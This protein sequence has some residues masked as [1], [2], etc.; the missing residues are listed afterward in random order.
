M[1]KTVASGWKEKQILQIFYFADDITLLANT[2]ADLQSMTTKL[3][4]K[5]ESHDY[6]RSHNV[7]TNNY[8]SPDNW[9]G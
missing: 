9:R 6:W 7:P 4:R 8:W 5:D 2:K 3:Q 1:T